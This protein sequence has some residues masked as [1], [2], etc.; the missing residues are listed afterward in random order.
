MTAA[1]PR[2][3][4]AALLC[5]LAGPVAAHPH[6][7][8]S[9]HLD[10][11]FDHAR[12]SAIHQTWQLDPQFS[13]MLL[14]DQAPDHRK[15]Q[16]L[17][18]AEIA[19]L[20][21]HAFANLAHYAYFTQVWAGDRPVTLGPARDYTAHL[22]GDALNYSFVTP[23][24]APADPHAAPLT[25]GVWDDSYY[26]DLEPTDPESAAVTVQGDSSCRATIAEDKGHPIYFGTVIPLAVR[27]ACP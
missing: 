14:Q 1:R 5:A 13:S 21:D 9:Y 23:L 20:R 2:A 4:L 25:I 19:A 26:V 15:G 3:G 17:T 6:V 27:I 24:A 7:W 8:I 16:P 12:L 10:L 11:M 18:P 22:T